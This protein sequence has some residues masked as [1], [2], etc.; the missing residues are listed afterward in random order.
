MFA[1]K[2]AL[3]DL[4]RITH[5]HIDRRV[6]AMLTEFARNG[7]T[8]AAIDAV[9]LVE[10]GISQKC[11]IVVG[12]VAD[13]EARISRVMERDHISH[14]YALMRVNAQPDDEYYT[15]VCSTVLENRGDEAE[16]QKQCE[17]FFGVLKMADKMK[18]RKSE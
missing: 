1:D 6:T 15:S 8:L 16:F 2:K 10:S 14:E 18:M 3:L 7:G 5:R 13:R 4:N 9:A 12:I 11:G 17:N